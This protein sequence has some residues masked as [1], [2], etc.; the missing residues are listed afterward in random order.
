MVIYLSFTI[1]AYLLLTYFFLR[2]DRSCFLVGLFSLPL[3]LVYSILILFSILR[4][5]DY[6]DLA[7]YYDLAVSISRGGENVL[8]LFWG[9][10]I[11]AVFNSAIFYVFGESLVGLAFLA[12]LASYLYFLLLYSAVTRVTRTESWM[13]LAVLVLFPGLGAQSS[14]IGKEMYILP[15]IGMIFWSF[16]RVRIN[17]VV[18]VFC[19]LLIGIIR[20]YQGAMVLGTALLTIFLVSRTKEKFLTLIFGSLLVPLF[21]FLTGGGLSSIIGK[22]LDV[23]LIGFMTSVYGVGN[24]GLPALPFPFS[25]LQ[26]FRPFPY[27]AHNALALFKSLENLFFMVFFFYLIFNARFLVKRANW[28]LGKVEF[29]F[30]VF[31]LLYFLINFTLFSFSQNIGDLSRRQVYFIPQLIIICFV[32]R[33]LKRGCRENIACV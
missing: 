23:G 28:L 17:Y 21:L 15:L 4:F 27:E 13:L 6:G 16:S 2:Y 22:I 31:C 14:Y 7:T 32:T 3:K 8:N 26:V 5:W 19:L 29:R 12:T 30:F 10:Y 33:K 24:T 18:V 1:F 11:V 20:P 9:S 25:V